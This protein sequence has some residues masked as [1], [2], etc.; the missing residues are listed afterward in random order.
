MKTLSNRDLEL[1][2]L[3]A[4]ISSNCIP[5]VE[6]HIPEARKA[7]LSDEQIHEAIR[8]SD[9]V[10]KVPARKVLEAAEAVLGKTPSE[11]TASAG[12]GCGE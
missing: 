3:G 4:A 1:V 10:R 6:Y 5:C 8:I 9:K 12:C 2:A 7:G 11:G